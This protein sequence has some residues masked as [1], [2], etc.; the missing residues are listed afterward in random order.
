MNSKNTG[1]PTILGTQPKEVLHDG[2]VVAGIRADQVLIGKITMEKTSEHG[3]PQPL[4]N[5][6]NGDISWKSVLGQFSSVILLD[7]KARK[8]R[9]LKIWGEL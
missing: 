6:K 8:R 3:R 4:F 2:D 9:P 1:E 5:F 7:C